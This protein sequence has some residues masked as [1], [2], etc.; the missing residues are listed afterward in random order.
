[1]K[2]DFKKLEEHLLKYGY[3]KNEMMPYD[4]F[5]IP[6]QTSYE[7]TMKNIEQF[8]GHNAM[9]YYGKEIPY[10][11]LPNLIEATADAMKGLGLQDGQ[12]VATLLPNIP[13]ALYMQYGPSKI[14]ASVSNIDPRTNSQL[15]LKF[16]E[17]EKLKSIVVVDVMYESAIR[18]IERE[19]KEIYGIERIV[20]VPAT[21]SLPFALRAISGIK[22][23][24]SGKERI[25]SDIV[26]V[27]YWNEL[28]S[29][30]R[31][32]H[33]TNIGYRKNM[34]AVV[35][36]SSGTSTGTPKSIPLTNENINSFV[37]KHRLTEFADLNPGTKLLHVLPYF[38][39]YGAINSAHLGINFGLTLQEIP[40]FSFKDFGYIAYK[41]GSE[42]MIGVPNWFNA[43]TKDPRLDGKSMSQVKMAISGGDSNTAKSKQE[44][45]DFL[46][47]H[48]AQ[49]I[50][51][52]GHGMSELGGSGSY[53][54]K[55]HQNGLGVGIPFPY[56]KYVVVSN[57][58]IVP[59]SEAGVRG[60]TYIYS[61]SATN[62]IFEGEK[63]VDTIEIEGFKF[64]NSK[65]TMHIAPNYEMEFISR[66]DRTFT[67]FDGHKVIP[68]DVEKQLLE[69]PSI[70][71]CMVV[72]YEDEEFFGKMP[73]AYIVTSDELTAKEKYQIVSDAVSRILTSTEVT[74]RE[75]PRKFS[76]IDA[77]P[78]NKMSK[79]DYKQLENRQL[80][81]SEY[82][83]TLDETNLKINGVSISEPQN[84][85]QKVKRR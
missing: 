35:Q 68:A 46:I 45:D 62:G 50:E 8:M 79:N 32:A 51:T 24:L 5:D 47:S 53:T 38:A 39:A 26:D 25:K 64:I 56:D 69:D 54:F 7:Y 40:E 29:N 71:K 1:M 80:D 77:L 85:T 21:N 23:K 10:D 83:V 28:I 2:V 49:C 31:F 73:I 58:Q 6:E 12:R 34:E 63:I 3:P 43:A 70:N 57:G 4:Y 52:N 55:G 33:A 44:D 82:T 81:G 84:A 65:D 78:Q 22:G 27:V 60:E 16:V 42:I 74:S 20:V 75:L 14:G 41:N 59:M 11:K 67:R 30:T 36:H 66:E 17:K 37:E 18:P 61:P 15:M 13:E 9:T 72:P 19:L 48:G 76:F